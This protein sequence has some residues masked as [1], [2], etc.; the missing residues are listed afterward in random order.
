MTSRAAGI[1]VE[2]GQGLNILTA[3]KDRIIRVVTSAQL[4]QTLSRRNAK[5]LLVGPDLV[6]CENLD[7]LDPAY[8]LS[9]SLLR[10]AIQLSPTRYV[11]FCN[12]L[13]DP[14]DLAAWLDVDPTALLSF[15][16]SDRDQ[17]LIVST[18]TFTI[19]QS[20]ALFKAMIKPAHTAIQAAPAGESAI[21]FVP[22]RSQCRSIA[23]DLITQCALEMETE[24][25]YLPGGISVLHLE[26]YRAR[27]HDQR[28]I[29]LVS[30][31]V[32]IFH[33]GV[34]KSD[35]NL[36]LELY[37]EGVIRVLVVPRDSCWNL[38]VRAAVVVVMGTQYVQLNAEGSNRQS[39]DYAL[40]DLVRM[41][42]RAVRHAGSGHFYLFC[43]A[44]AKDTFLRFLNEGLPLESGLQ[45]S[46][47]LEHWYRDSALAQDKQ[48]LV[49]ALSFTFLAQRIASNPSYYDC[50]SSSRDENLSRLVDS[51]V[52]KFT[53]RPEVAS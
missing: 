6:V 46:E 21:I 5:T 32:G 30:R 15:Q 34:D 9:I 24:T 45:D 51:L 11:G 48:Q 10:H 50:T 4:L 23:F 37:A 29:D 18:Q 1:N 40:S 47:E 2:F 16:P 35:R 8:E 12:S 25:G 27:L 43:Q 38:P 42:S 20:A 33:E 41:Q 17:S 31:G 53:S 28:L 13:N 22:S 14:V 52:A 19:P 39:R 36:I 49:D 7:Q 26:G 44:E 3:P